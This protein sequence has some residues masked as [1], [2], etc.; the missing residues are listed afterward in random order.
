[1]LGGWSPQKFHWSILK[2]LIFVLSVHSCKKLC[3]K[4]EFSKK[5]GICAWM[6]KSINMPSNSWLDT[7]FFLQKHMTFDHI[8]NNI[9]IIWTSFISGTPS[10]ICKF[11]SSL[12][13]KLFYLFLQFRGLPIIP[14]GKEFHLNIRKDP[15]RIFNQFLNY[16][17]NNQFYISMLW[18]LIGSWIILINSFDPSN[19]IMSMSY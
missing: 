13:Y 6:S 16:R 2:F 17:V 12:L 1:M 9:F 5:S 3:F 10:S 15:F 8:I 19:I 14:H 4:T 18:I 7:K 11:K